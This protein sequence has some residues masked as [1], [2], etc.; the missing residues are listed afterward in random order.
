MG[1]TTLDG[2]APEW[3]GIA[4]GLMIVGL[5]IVLFIDQAGFFGWQ[6]SWSVWPFLIIGAGLARFASPRADGSRGGGWLIFFGVWLLLNEMRVL[7]FRD[8]WPLILVAIGVHTMW[9]ALVRPARPSRPRAGQ[10]S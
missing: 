3:A 1:M 2:R 8:S 4:I 9:K 10:P 7:R 5:G 6:P